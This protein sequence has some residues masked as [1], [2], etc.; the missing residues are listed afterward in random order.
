MVKGFSVF[1]TLVSMNIL[2][3]KYEEMSFLVVG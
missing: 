1:L 2:K 3:G